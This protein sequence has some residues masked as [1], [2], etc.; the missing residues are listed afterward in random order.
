LKE[1]IKCSKNTNEIEKD[2]RGWVELLPKTQGGW[3]NY[4]ETQ[5]GTWGSWVLKLKNMN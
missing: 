1:G 2:L 5:V 3:L 4:I